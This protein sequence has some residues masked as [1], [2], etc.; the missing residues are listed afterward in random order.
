MIVNKSISL[1]MSTSLLFGYSIS[2]I[3]IS[4]VAAQEDTV[5]LNGINELAVHVVVIVNSNS[6]EI[7]ISPDYSIINNL[8]MAR[9]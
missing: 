1:F 5:G 9:R 2:V 4:H 6:S 7:H 8:S 3:G